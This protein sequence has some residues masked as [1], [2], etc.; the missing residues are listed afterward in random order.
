MKPIMKATM[1]IMGTLA[2]LTLGAGGA[3]ATPIMP[4]AT[5]LAS[6]LQ[7]AQYREVAGDHHFKKCYREFVFGRYVCHHYH[8]W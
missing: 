5:P 1:T 2:M 3:G 6:G 7:L 4:A 8:Y